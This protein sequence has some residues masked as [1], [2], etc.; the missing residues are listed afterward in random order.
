MNLA[1]DEA[2]VRVAG[3]PLARDVRVDPRAGTL[4]W[5]GRTRA[6]AD[7]GWQPPVAGAVYGVLLND[8]GTLA[9]LGDTVHAPPYR[10]PPNAPVLYVRPRNTRSAH[11]RPVVVPDG[12]DALA[13][14]ASLAIVIGRTACR[15]A[16][17][18]AP[19]F[20][21]GYTVASDFCIPHDSLYRPAVRF[22]CR[23]GFC[24][25]G[26]WAIA[27]RHV[28]DPD[29]LEIR[30]EVDGALRQR[31]TTRDLVRPIARLVADVSA[32]MTLAP[33]D[34]LLTGVPADAP[35]ARRGQRVAV[36]V[37]GVG[38]LEN[39]LVDAAEAA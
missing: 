30:V 3:E 26:P 29:A 10:A 17:A 39:T 35:H 36:T 38:T 20:V 4:A 22:R 11:R 25:L 5:R 28:P 13:I 12:V 14:G 34:V 32:F 27:R 18:D 19:D 23:D 31:A 37:A 8:K 33:G 1:I 7:L 2:L 15:V 6:A 9:A 21:A 24:A 16:A